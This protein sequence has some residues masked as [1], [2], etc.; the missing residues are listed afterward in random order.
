M[1]DRAPSRPQSF[2]LSS[3][4]HIGLHFTSY[5]WI[6][7]LGNLKNL[8]L[9]RISN[10]FWQLRSC[11]YRRE[12]GMAVLAHVCARLCVRGH[13][14]LTTLPSQTIS[15]FVLGPCP[16]PWPAP[17][18]LT[19]LSFELMERVSRTQR[20]STHTHSCNGSFDNY[21]GTHKKMCAK[22]FHKMHFVKL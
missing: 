11:V 6:L 13:Q 15:K 22:L 16:F 5:R 8:P 21:I 4:L 7:S 20:Q 2:R 3:S 14:P 1:S 12:D 19:I 9:T 17:E 10:T 18:I